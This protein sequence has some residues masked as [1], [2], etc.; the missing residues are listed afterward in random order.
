M[1]VFSNTAVMSLHLPML[2]PLITE[3]V[4]S[5]MAKQDV[6]WVNEA[7]WI[8][9]NVALRAVVGELLTTEMAEQIFPL[10]KRMSSGCLALVRST[11]IQGVVRSCTQHVFRLLRTSAHKLSSSVAHR[12][13]FLSLNDSNCTFTCCILLSVQGPFDLRC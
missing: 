13:S 1:Q 8:T 5:V 3:K 7:H 4:R 9:F 6:L 2:I 10:F 12:F 11:R